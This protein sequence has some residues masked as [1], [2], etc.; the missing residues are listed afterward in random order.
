MSYHGLINT[1]LG[2]HL[3]MS[4]R[5]YEEL[6]ARYDFA[7]LPTFPQEGY[8]TLLDDHFVVIKVSQHQE[9]QEY[10]RENLR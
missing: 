4:Y 1:Y 2:F 5:S 7:A 8:L 3:P 9:Y 6:A 10:T